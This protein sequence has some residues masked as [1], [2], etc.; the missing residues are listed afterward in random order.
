MDLH[1]GRKYVKAGQ[2]PMISLAQGIN[3]KTIIIEVET[4]YTNRIYF[5]CPHS[6]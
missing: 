4:T 1:K 3:V 2:S 5:V 6:Y